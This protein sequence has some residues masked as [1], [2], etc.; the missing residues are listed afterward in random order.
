MLPKSVEENGKRQLEKM[1]DAIACKEFR[2][3]NLE[4]LL[5]TKVE[6]EGLNG[7]VNITPDFRVAVQKIS[8]AGVHIIIHANG[9]SSDTLDY[10]VNGDELS[11][12][13]HILNKNCHCKSAA[14]SGDYGD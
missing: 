11:R 3:M 12:I 6:F 5:R 2:I 9:H 14:K 1:N 7:K 13:D 10:M 8:D 4:K